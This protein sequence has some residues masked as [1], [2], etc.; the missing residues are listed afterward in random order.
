MAASLTAAPS[1]S[2]PSN[3]KSANLQKMA[4]ELANPESEQNWIRLN[5]LVSADNGADKVDDTNQ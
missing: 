4:N 5:E 1:L 2:S 3:L